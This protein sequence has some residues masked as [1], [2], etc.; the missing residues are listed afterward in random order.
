MN[1]NT[2]RALITGITGQD[3]SYLTELLLSK[4][5]T[6]HGITLPDEDTTLL[7]DSL[8]N[9]KEMLFIYHLSLL[10]LNKVMTTVKRMK[11]DECYHLA[12]LSFISFDPDDEAAILK[13]NILSTHNLLQAI[14]HCSPQCLFFFAGSSEMF[15][16]VDHEPQN[17]TTVFRPRNVYGISKLAGHHLVEYYRNEKGLQASTGILYNHESPRRGLKF[18]TRK[19][20][21]GAVRIKMGLQKKLL[22]GNLDASRDWGH[23]NDYVNAMFQIL[24]KTPNEDYVIACGELH[25]VRDFAELAF[26]IVGLDYLDYVEISPEFYRE[27]DKINLCGDITKIKTK[28]GWHPQRS[29][30]DI[31]TE[32]VLQDLKNA[33]EDS[34][35]VS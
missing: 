23:A 11:P 32:M 8:L 9:Y 35:M 25:S 10:D 13:N 30:Q 28:V 2:R 20:S 1:H 33:R 22:L 29:F 12:A 6:V 21:L 4:G 17:E 24:N 16:D 34:S 3:G 5:Y 15:G 26:S 19:I 27:V 14:H 7:H 31:V 18:V